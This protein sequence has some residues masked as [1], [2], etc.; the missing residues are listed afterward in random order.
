MANTKFPLPQHNSPTFC[1][2]VQK[3]S[4]NGFNIS[5]HKLGGVGISAFSNSSSALAIKCDAIISLNL[6]A[7]VL[8]YISTI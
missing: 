8:L 7:G 5:S 2:D 3:V 6:L 4:G 1:L